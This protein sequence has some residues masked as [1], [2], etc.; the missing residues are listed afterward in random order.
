MGGLVDDGNE[1]DIAASGVARKA[2]RYRTPTPNWSVCRLR[3][4][5]GV[6]VSGSVSLLIEGSRRGQGADLVR[7]DD[8]EIE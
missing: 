8:N 1:S 3:E 7:L 6:D 5:G 2:R 4:R